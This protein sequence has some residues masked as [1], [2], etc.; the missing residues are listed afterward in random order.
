MSDGVLRGKYLLASKVLIELM[1]RTR[2]ETTAIVS[3]LWGNLK[4]ISHV[5]HNRAYLCL[6]PIKTLAMITRIYIVHKETN[7]KTWCILNRRHFWLVK[8]KERLVEALSITRIQQSF[9]L[10]SLKNLNLFSCILIEWVI[11]NLLLPECARDQIH[12][13]EKTNLPMTS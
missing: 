13:T 8:Q 7:V 11:L 12:K 4:Q 5:P 3:H 2:K 6:V 9:S 10:L 1:R